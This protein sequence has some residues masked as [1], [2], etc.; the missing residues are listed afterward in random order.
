MACI[1]LIVYSEVYVKE[2]YVSEVY[3]KEDVSSLPLLPFS[4][5][6]SS[7]PALLSNEL[8]KVF[9]CDIGLLSHRDGL[10]QNSPKPEDD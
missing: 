3:V 2:A 4:L 9:E 5:L 7:H 6:C 1:L 8:F 10:W